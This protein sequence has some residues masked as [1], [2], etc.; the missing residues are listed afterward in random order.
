[1]RLSEIFSKNKNIVINSD[2]DGIL[3]GIILNKY[4]GC[5]IVGF[6][7]SKEAVWLK[8]GIGVYDPVYIDLY[9]V[10]PD[11]ICIEQHIIAT[12]ANHLQQLKNLGTKLNPN[13][14]RGKVFTDDYYHKYPFGTVHYLITLMEEEGIKVDL[15]NLDEVITAPNGTSITIG[16]LI[17]RADDALYSSLGP[18]ADNA[19]DWWNWLVRK[20]NHAASVQLLDLEVS[21]TK[22]ELNKA[23]KEKTGVFFVQGFGCNGKD[24][25]FDK[26][27]DSNECIRT[28]FRDFIFFVAEVMNNLDITVPTFLKAHTGVFKKRIVYGHQKG[29]LDQLINDP[30][31]FSYAFIYGPRAQYPNYSY[32]TNLK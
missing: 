26:V 3:S 19:Q 25:A 17:L 16:Q 21:S 32:T 31:L 4:Y 28:E 12:D 18:Y 30:T 29:L 14:D 10:N 11:V 9:V 20:S 13:L 6:S 8:P 5:E 22:K 27:T 1:M 15:P 2:I 24:G 23:I 7:N